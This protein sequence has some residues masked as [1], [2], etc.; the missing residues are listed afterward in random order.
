MKERSRQ[1]FDSWS[2]GCAVAR[3]RFSRDGFSVPEDMNKYC[4]TISLF[5]LMQQVRASSRTHR[6]SPTEAAAGEARG[7]KVNLLNELIFFWFFCFNRA[8][9]WKTL[10]LSLSTRWQSSFIHLCLYLSGPGSGFFPLTVHDAIPLLNMCNYSP[11]AR[12]TITE[13][14]GNSGKRTK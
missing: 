4:L 14:R 12:H 13:K 2:F 7:G 11:H 10:G 5:S 3:E 8:G 9:V 6:K 1:A